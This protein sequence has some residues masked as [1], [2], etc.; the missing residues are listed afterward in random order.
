M[1]DPKACA[2]KGL[3][4]GTP[5]YDDCI[6]YKGAYAN[7]GKANPVKGSLNKKAMRKSGG[8]Y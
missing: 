4:P 3:K 7:K 1:P 6:S 2:A 8:S 5:E